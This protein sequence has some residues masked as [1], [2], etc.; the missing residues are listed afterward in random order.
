MFIHQQHVQQMQELQ[1]QEWVRLITI[2]NHP[3]RIDPFI[4]RD[5][6]DMESIPFKIC[7]DVS[8]HLMLA[9]DG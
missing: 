6:D 3:N 9:F 2:I 8:K 5:T 7:N 4:A 1:R